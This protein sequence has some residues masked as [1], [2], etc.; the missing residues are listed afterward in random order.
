MESPKKE[1]GC[2]NTLGRR[3]RSVTLAQKS[4]ENIIS[5]QQL[6]GGRNSKE[7]MPTAGH[8][9]R[10]LESTLNGKTETC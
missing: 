6:P 3:T 8:T 10:N 7:S 4:N 2:R 5:Q 9:L 1:L